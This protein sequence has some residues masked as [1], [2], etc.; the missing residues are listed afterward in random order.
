MWPSS[1]DK[2][3]LELLH[4]KANV[5]TDSDNVGYKIALSFFLFSLN[6]FA[7]N[8]FY[9]VKSLLNE[10]LGNFWRQMSSAPLTTNWQY[11]S[12][13]YHYW[14]KLRGENN[15]IARSISLLIKLL[16]KKEFFFVKS[17][18]NDI[19]LSSN[20]I[21]ELLQMS[22]APLVSN[23]QYWSGWYHCWFKLRGEN[24]K[25]FH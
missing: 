8:K 20:N 1:T 16:C 11:W 10:L 18:L 24:N 13:W 5:K 17:L 12:G 22:S 3:V 6:C 19:W 7:E 15:K 14:F 21:W 25:N 2:F 23:W 9:F 4:L